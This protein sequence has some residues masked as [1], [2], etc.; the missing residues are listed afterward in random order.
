MVRFPRQGDSSNTVLIVAPSSIAHK[1]ESE[2]SKEISSLASRVVWGVVVPQ[3]NHAAV[4]G[5]GAQNLQ[6]TQRKHG[7]K[8]Y[9][10]GWNDYAQAGEVENK[11]EDSEVEQAQEKDLVK[12]VG[13]KESV[14]A[15]AKE[16]QSIK[17]RASG[18]STPTAG[19]PQST[20]QHSVKVLVPKKFH[21]VVAQGGRFFRS[22]PNG[23]RVSHEG[24]KPPS[25]TLK[26]KK[27]PVSTAN[28]SSSA[29]RI[30]KVE[31]DSPSN[32]TDGGIEFQLVPIHEEN[33]SNGDDEEQD[34]IP[35]VIES[36]NE[37]DAQKVA[38]E[39]RKSLERAKEAT[40]IGWVTVPRGMSEFLSLFSSLSSRLRLRDARWK[41]DSFVFH[42]KCHESSVEEDQ[43]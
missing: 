3:P 9:M 8:I 28:G 19:G 11:S 39:I 32:S 14:L 42:Q 5:K 26:A 30:D 18:T 12:I 41:T 1:I 34:T 27:P 21:A 43:V 24:V 10:P 33:G 31:I 23:T 2:L 6:E 7:V 40:H 37:E 15:A 22:L 29:A 25:S 38:E 35:W 13:P 20:N 17:G 36:R 4:I 16:L